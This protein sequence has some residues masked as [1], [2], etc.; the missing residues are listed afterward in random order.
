MH[1]KKLDN[2]EDILSNGT[3]NTNIDNLSDVFATTASTIQF[4]QGL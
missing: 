1:V 2:I 4:V 3:I